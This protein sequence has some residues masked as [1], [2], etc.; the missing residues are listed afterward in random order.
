MATDNKNKKAKEEKKT[1]EKAPKTTNKTT[2]KTTTK[3]TNAPASTTKKTVAANKKQTSKTIKST[4]SKTKSTPKKSTASKSTTG[5]KVATEKA[6]TTANKEKNQTKVTT[7]KSTTQTKK[8]TTTAN[9]TKNSTPKKKQENKTIK[10]VI[11]DEETKKKGVLESTTVSH[12]EII[13][14]D[15]FKEGSFEVDPSTAKPVEDLI[16]IRSIL[17]AKLP[18]GTSKKD[19]KERKKFYCRD[20]FIFATI[21]PVLDLFAMLFIEPYKPLLICNTEWINYA[22]TVV[23]DFVLIFLL[24]YVLDFIFGEEDVKNYNKL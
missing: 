22:V 5:K 24:T 6:T 15:Y 10:P 3:K 13:N 7:Q 2:T 16:D 12:G 23:G 19:R 18:V 21:I 17:G 14:E 11:I 4:A 9:K 1:T 20:A 8:K